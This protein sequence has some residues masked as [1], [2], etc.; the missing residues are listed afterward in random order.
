MINFLSLKIDDSCLITAGPKRFM[1]LARAY[2]KGPFAE[3]VRARMFISDAQNR[4]VCRTR[5]RNIVFM[6]RGLPV[7]ETGTSSK[8]HMPPAL[9]DFTVTQSDIIFDH[10]LPGAATKEPEVVSEDSKAGLSLLA[11]FTHSNLVPMFGPWSLLNTFLS[12][13]YKKVILIF[14]ILYFLGGTRDQT[15]GPNSHSQSLTYIGNDPRTLS[16]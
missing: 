10:A 16:T 14:L 13:I 5:I 12:Q 1:A 6:S 8:R 11:L 2:G 7:F 9:K 15:K 3:D 4:L